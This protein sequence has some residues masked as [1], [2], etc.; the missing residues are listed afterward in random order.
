M[1]HPATSPPPLQAEAR[2]LRDNADAAAWRKKKRT[3][4]KPVF[5]HEVHAADSNYR[6]YEKRIATELNPDLDAYEVGRD[7]LP[8]CVF[9]G[10]IKVCA[11]GAP[12][13]G[14]LRTLHKP[15][16]LSFFFFAFFHHL[17]HPQAEQ[18]RLAAGSVV[19]PLYGA[20]V[21]ETARARLVEAMKAQEER[22]KKFSRRRIQDDDGVVHAI[23]RKNLKFVNQATRAFDPYT[24][25]IRANLERGTAL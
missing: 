6:S 23:N 18:A 1:T 16:H 21:S 20:T 10:A 14:S 25:E 3:K 15:N 4:A 13:L 17:T 8:L 19:E 24:V 7:L 12:N 11:S 9:A 2:L 22:R 5:G